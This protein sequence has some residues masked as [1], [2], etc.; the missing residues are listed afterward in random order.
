MTDPVRALGEVLER[1]GYVDTSLPEALDASEPL[2]TLAALFGLGSAVPASALT[3]VDVAA[4]E[5]EGVL[6]RATASASARLCGSA[7]GTGC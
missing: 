7:S 2:P 6:E 5:A 4:L 3:G 1:A